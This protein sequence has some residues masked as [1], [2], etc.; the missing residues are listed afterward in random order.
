[1]NVVGILRFVSCRSEVDRSKV[2]CRRSCKPSIVLGKKRF[3]LAR[4]F[5]NG[6]HGTI[7]M[8]VSRCVNRKRDQVTFLQVA[9]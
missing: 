4:S 3:M 2:F 7:R 8:H 1:M 9:K 6:S 5:E